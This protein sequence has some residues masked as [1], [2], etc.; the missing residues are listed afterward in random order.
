MNAEIPQDRT[1]ET[2]IGSESVADTI[3]PRCERPLGRLGYALQ[4][5]FPTAGQPPSSRVRFDQVANKSFTDEMVWA[6]YLP[7]MGQI[8]FTDDKTVMACYDIIPVATEGR[9]P[10]LLRNM[11]HKLTPL[12]HTI[13]PEHKIDPWVMGIYGYSQPAIEGAV[14]L[15]R[16][17]AH[18][19][20]KGSDYTEDYLERMAQH[21]DDVTC[22]GG[23]FHD[24]LVSDT[25]WGG[26]TQRARIVLY[27]PYTRSLPTI[28]PSDELESICKKLEN[29]FKSLNIK[30]SR[31]DGRDFFVW[32]RDFFNPAPAICDEDTTKLDTVAPWPGDIGAESV[33]PLSFDIGEA[34]TLTPPVVDQETGIWYWDGLPTAVI[35]AESITAVPQPGAL[36]GEIERDNLRFTILE[37]L[38]A[39]SLV[40]LNIIFK[41]R[42]DTENEMML[43]QT[44]AK[45]E[46][47]VA[48]ATR[49]EAQIIMGYMEETKEPMY[50][51]ELAVYV[52]ARTVSELEEFVSDSMITLQLVGVKCYDPF[53]EHDPVKASN[54][55]RAL[56]GLYK[57][58]VHLKAARRTKLVHSNH[59]LRFAPIYGRSRGSGKP[60]VAWFNRSGE[61]T[62]IDLLDN[63]LNGH[64]FIYGSSG[65]G[66]SANNVAMLDSLIAMHR[67]RIFII[68]LGNSFGPLAEYASS[69]GVSTHVLQLGMQTDVSMP[70][71][72]DALQLVHPAAKVEI[73]PDSDE[74]GD[75]PRDILGELE[76]IAKQMIAGASGQKLESNTIR[77]AIQHAIQLSA[78]KAAGGELKY[79][80]PR[81]EDIADS[82]SEIALKDSD[83]K[84]EEIEEAANG[85]RLFC[86]GLNGHL[87]NRGG[88]SLP[89][90][91]LTIMDMADAGQAGRSDTLIIAVLALVMH[92]NRIAER[93]QHTGRPIVFLIDEGHMITSHELLMTLM[94]KITKMW[95]KLGARFWMA[96]QEI[97][98]IPQSVKRMIGMMEYWVA[99]KMP[100]AQV[101]LTKEFRPISSEQASMMRQSQMNR[102]KFSEGC[103]LRDNEVVQFRSVPPS[104]TLALSQTNT[105]EK[106]ARRKLM[107]EN[108][109]TE[110][111]AIKIMAE[112]IR[113]GRLKSGPEANTMKRRKGRRVIRAA[114]DA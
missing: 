2:L 45:G 77:M 59:I 57:P 24:D 36:T 114:S 52:R 22:K 13:V 55:I 61:P 44:S 46:S 110:A 25:R 18:E 90:V 82:L 95:R 88:K 50:P 26:Q 54:F 84:R 9:S 5:L 85:M 100:A 78:E 27:R 79:E 19:R 65:S 80:I 70:P 75:E 64:T 7:E 42:Q 10:A 49:N 98:D 14:E 56:P 87:F 73:D 109:C 20:A 99:M 6:E 43:V 16:D 23:Y 29:A 92:I 8:A 15:M 32:M 101:E 106:A 74:P 103:V 105:D 37:K 30:A 47:H 102:G 40:A 66:K 72:A 17:Y 58:S 68:D 113:Q 1:T 89:E 60:G 91:D 35:Q 38:P 67:P 53:S 12:I 93:D 81:P 41:P 39:N 34:V 83:G 3:S 51:C 104:L 108:K 62:F 76:I 97:E 112:Q 11:V 31:M 107:D 96:T 69:K 94:I 111:E 21:Y 4:R 48:V 33:D 86:A 71:F 63:N 28:D